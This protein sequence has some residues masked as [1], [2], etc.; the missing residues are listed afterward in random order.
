MVEVPHWLERYHSRR[1]ELLRRA[2]VHAIW[3]IDSEHAHSADVCMALYRAL[4][5]TGGVPRGKA[6]GEAG[7]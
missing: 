5:Q 7:Q 1:A 3:L 4:Q 6:V 2:I